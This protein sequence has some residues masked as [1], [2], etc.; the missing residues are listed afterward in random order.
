VA[1][2]VPWAR[3]SHAGLFLPIV[4]TPVHEAFNLL[5]FDN[6]DACGSEVSF[7]RKGKGKVNVK[8]QSLF[9]CPI[10]QSQQRRGSVAEW[11]SCWTQAQKGLGSNHSRNAVS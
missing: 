9:I 5:V 10:M 6:E 7:G 1:A 3:H 11:L 2:A 4:T 8:R